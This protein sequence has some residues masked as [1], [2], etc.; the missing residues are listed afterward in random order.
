MAQIIEDIISTDKQAREIVQKAQNKRELILQSAKKDY[1]RLVGEGE[2]KLKKLKQSLKNENNTYREELEGNAY[3]E[4]C[5]KKAQLDN[6]YSENEQKWVQDI[7]ET[8][9][10]V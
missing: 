5:E 10:K 1:E 4:L 2:D 8:L 9:T 3:E 7:F 6:V